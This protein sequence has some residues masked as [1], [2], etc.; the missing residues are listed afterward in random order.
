MTDLYRNDQVF[1]MV[2]EGEI[3]KLLS[4]FS[5]SYVIDVIDRNLANRFSYNPVSANPNIVSSFEMNFKDMMNRYPTDQENCMNVRHETYLTII[6]K[7]CNAFNMQYVG[8]EPDLFSIAYNLYDLF[9]SGYSRNIIK[10]FST[11]IYANRNILYANMGLERYKKSKDSSSS[12]VKRIYND[13][14]TA[15][16]ITRIKDVIYYISGFDINLYQF[17]SSVYSIPVADY[18]IQN[19]QPTGMS[20]LYKDEFCA[21]A[22]AT[23]TLLTEIRSAIQQMMQA[24]M[25]QQQPII[26]QVADNDP[27]DDYQNEAE[28]E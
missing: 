5:D 4:Q 3:A 25:I 10:F 23:P 14:V 28:G 1:T 15:I 27:D 13:P 2:A 8:N 6:N 22:M 26:G 21:K 19:I 12:S 24:D 16:V 7:I 20:D 11:Y 9:V 17:L 18:I